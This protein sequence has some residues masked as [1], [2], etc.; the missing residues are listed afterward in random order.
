MPRPVPE[1]P[2]TPLP[3][4]KTTPEPLR[5]RSE[6]AAAPSSRRRRLVNAAFVFVAI[7]L[8]IDALVGEKGLVE[9]L[10]ARKEAQVEEGRLVALKAENAR[11]RE[12]KRRLNEDPSRIEAE[13]RRQLGL[14]RPGEVMFILKDVQPA[15]LTRPG[16]R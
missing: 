13:A 2:T 9:T 7:V 6:P 4:R 12:E 16:G 8:V 3:R 14:V 15:S 1:T 11:L 5:R 10:R